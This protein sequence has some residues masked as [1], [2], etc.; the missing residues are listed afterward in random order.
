MRPR[1]YPMR[2]GASSAFGDGLA[3]GP[4]IQ[5]ARD[6]RARTEPPLEEGVETPGEPLR[7]DEEELSEVPKI[8]MDDSF[9]G[10]NLPGRVKQSLTQLSTKEL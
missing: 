6:S 2:S 7:E 5:K 1:T 3:I 4:T 9:L 10:G 8:S